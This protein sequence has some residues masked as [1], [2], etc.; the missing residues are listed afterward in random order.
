MSDRTIFHLAIPVKNLAEARTFYCE[1]LGCQIGR[2][3]RGAMILN[4]YGHQL[5]THM[6]PDPIAPQKGIYPRH[7]GLVFLTLPEWEAN[8]TRVKQNNLSFYQEPKIRF[9]G[10]LTEHR[11]FFL[12][13]PFSNLLEFKFYTHFEAVFG[14][15]E[16][17]QVGDRV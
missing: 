2:E 15:R 6:T 16:F 5:V 7:F 11:T 4:F 17:S 14:S 12:E 10:Q 8:L 9:P 13:D 1:G 3:S